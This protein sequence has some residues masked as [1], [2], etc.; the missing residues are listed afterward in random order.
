MISYSPYTDTKTVKKKTVRAFILSGCR[1]AANIFTMRARA[2]PVRA[3][4]S[5]GD[6][7]GGAVSGRVWER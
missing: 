7:L 2:C 6:R 5:R 1:S 3:V 4:A